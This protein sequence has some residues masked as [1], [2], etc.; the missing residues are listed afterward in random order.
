MTSKVNLS[1]QSEFKL[2]QLSPTSS[3]TDTAHGSPFYNR[4]MR[5]VVRHMSGFVPVE[6][7]P[8]I[9]SDSVPARI[10]NLISL[11]KS[12]ER[13]SLQVPLTPSR[14]QSTDIEWLELIN[15]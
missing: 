3:I 5:I 10:R 9:N 6:E 15:Y 7:T 2:V 1:Q 8:A 14:V 4:D 13:P 11:V 12:G